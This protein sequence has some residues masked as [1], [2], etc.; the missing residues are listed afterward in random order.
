[1]KKGP[2]KHALAIVERFKQAHENLLF[3]GTQPPESWAQIEK[4][5]ENASLELFSVL[6][7][8]EPGS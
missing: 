7:T 5:Y 2:S 6:S 8:K 4:A 1:M 3:M